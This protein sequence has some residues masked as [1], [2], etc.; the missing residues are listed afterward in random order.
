MSSDLA[1]PAKRVEVLSSHALG[2]HK[3]VDVAA[4][5]KLHYQ[6]DV[7]GK[8]VGRYIGVE[9]GGELSDV[10][11]EQEMALGN[12]RHLRPLPRLESSCFDLRRWPTRV[13]NFKDDEEVKK[14]YY[15]EVEALIKETTG[16]QR[17]LVFDHTLRDTSAGSALNVKMGDAAA[18]VERVHTD[19]SDT[20]GPRR[21]KSLA[22]SGGYTGLQLSEAEK[23]DILSRQ[24]CIVNVWRNI[25]DEPVQ[26]KP[27]ALLDP[28]SLGKDDFV[29]YEMQ[30]AERKGENYA[31][32]YNSNHQ[33]YFYP[34]MEKDE[35]L[36]F[37]T[38]ESRTDRPRYCFHTAFTDLNQP[39]DAPPRA[40]IEVRTIAIMP[41]EPQV[42]S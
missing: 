31:L 11:A 25:K 22:E 16:A 20:S 9:D 8:R 13:K 12:A 42:L 37:K 29:T 33:W 32:R 6:Q 41:K 15:P 4:R 14:V 23:E 27:L 7:R 24:F 30:Y 1:A 21:I 17:V 19:Y 5:A 40:S 2:S 18:A 3:R 10:H 35:C 36:V 39:A 26:S 38:W 34:L 28:A